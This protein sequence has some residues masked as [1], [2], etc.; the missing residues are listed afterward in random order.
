M[1]LLEDNIRTL[2]VC[3]VEKMSSAGTESTVCFHI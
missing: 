2:S 1:E 3:G